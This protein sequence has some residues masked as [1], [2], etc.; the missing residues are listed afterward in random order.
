M[1]GLAVLLLAR[2]QIC[3]MQIW[4]CCGDDLRMIR[5]NLYR[6]CGL[7]AVHDLERIDDWNPN[8]SAPA[9]YSSL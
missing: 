9:I 6:A 2:L 5:G 1:V 4:L 3:E 7:G 8:K